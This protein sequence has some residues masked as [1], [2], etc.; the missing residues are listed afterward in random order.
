MQDNP[1]ARVPFPVNPIYS[2]P[3]FKYCYNGFTTC[4]KTWGLRVYNSTYVYSYGAGLYSFFDN[5]DSTCLITHNCQVNT[6]AI[7]QSEAVYIYSLATVGVDNMAQVDGSNLV[8]HTPNPSIFTDGIII[9][10]YP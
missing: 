1:D 6:L 4:Y 8:S 10:E 7:E 3:D 5:Y 9:F 2:D